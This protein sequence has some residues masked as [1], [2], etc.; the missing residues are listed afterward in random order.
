MSTQSLTSRQ[1]AERAHWRF[2][3]IKKGV[4]F[5]SSLTNEDADLIL[6][7]LG[8][9]FGAHYG[10][11]TDQDFY[12]DVLRG[13]NDDRITAFEDFLKFQGT[14]QPPTRLSLRPLKAFLSHYSGHRA[15]V[16]QVKYA[17]EEYG[18]EP[19]VA[20]DDLPPGK[21]YCQEMESALRKS[22]VLIAFLTPEYKSRPFCM[23]EIGIAYGI[24]MPI[25]LLG[26]GDIPQG[27]VQRIQCSQALRQGAWKAPQQFAAQI[28]SLIMD[29]ERL[30]YQAAHSL[31]WSLCN[32]K[33]YATTR[34]SVKAL[35]SMRLKFWQ[36]S[37]ADPIMSAL[38]ENDQVFDVREIAETVGRLFSKYGDATRAKEV[39]DLVARQRGI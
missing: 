24:H 31:V 1:V 21:D 2:G 23:Q 14:P 17:L 32:A 38:R 16:T 33:N 7:S 19:F 27:F 15:V 25:V 13:A 39:A 4:N 6:D 20:H 34:T 12:T 10:D 11:Q 35:H 9:G 36:S 28:H 37:F 29:D 18:L 30:A 26:L 22:D 8:V 3:L 5:L